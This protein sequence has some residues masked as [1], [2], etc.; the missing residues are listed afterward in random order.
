MT[1]K[2]RNLSILG[3]LE[4]IKFVPK[5]G[6]VL[7]GLKKFDLTPKNR[8]LTILGCLDKVK[9]FQKNCKKS[10]KTEILQTGQKIALDEL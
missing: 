5:N 3:F 9:F 1:L 8:N 10:E 2:N 7:R 4:K 6:G